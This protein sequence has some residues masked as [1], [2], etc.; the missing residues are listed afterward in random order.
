[1]DRLA[2]PDKSIDDFTQQ[3]EWELLSRDYVHKEFDVQKKHN[4]IEDERNYVEYETLL[5]P[6]LT[7]VQFKKRYGILK[8]I[9]D[10]LEQQSHELNY[11]N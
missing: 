9:L 10:S 11:V 1:L 5:C 4:E 6:L 7:V 3:V 2:E 8:V